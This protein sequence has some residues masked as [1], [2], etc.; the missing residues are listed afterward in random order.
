M[1]KVFVLAGVFLCATAG[2]HKL[3]AASPSGRFVVMAGTGSG[4][5]VVYDSKTGLEW[6]QTA[7]VT[8]SWA[9]AKTYCAG[10]N[11]ALG[12]SVFRLPTVKEL[13]TVLDYSY[14]STSGTY[15]FASEFQISGTFFSFWSATVLGGASAQA[16]PSS[17]WYLDSYVG[18]IGT[19]STTSLLGVRCVR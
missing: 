4:N 2:V 12:G 13:M 14:S 19:Q 18:S 17:A 10:A 15:H 7:S 1:R 8:Y 11:T 5:G 3:H 6:Q 16:S 9:N